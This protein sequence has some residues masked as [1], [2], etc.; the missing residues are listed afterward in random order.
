VKGSVATKNFKNAKGIELDPGGGENKTLKE[1]HVPS[2]T[3][4]KDKKGKE[5]HGRKKETGGRKRIWEGKGPR[6]K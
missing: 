3:S 1:M 4:L 5:G 6:S 2:I